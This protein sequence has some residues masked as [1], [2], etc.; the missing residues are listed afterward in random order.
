MYDS[1]FT[2]YRITHPSCPVSM[3]RDAD[4][5]GAVSAACKEN[6]LGFG[7][8]YSKPDWHHGDYWW[9]YFPTPDRHVNYDP[10]RYPERWQRFKDFTHNQIEEIVTRYAPDILW[11]DGGWV[12]P[13]A[14]GTVLDPDLVGVDQGPSQDIDMARIVATARRH[15]PELLVVDRTVHGEYENYR[16]P[17]RRVPDRRLPYPWESC[18][19]LGTDWY[20]SR[21]NDT[22]KSAG[23][24]IRTL[25][26]IV[27]RGGNM[28][29]GIGPDAHGDLI[30]EVYER[31]AEIGDWLEVNG[32]AIYETRPVSGQE[33]D[34]KFLTQSTIRS[35]VYVLLPLDRRYGERLVLPHLDGREIR[36][37]RMLGVASGP[38]WTYESGTPVVDLSGGLLDHAQLHHVACLAVDFDE[39]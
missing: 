13:K 11:L 10:E 16:T 8:Y 22:Y 7:T 9:R 36:A 27:A 19:M 28:L 24:I 31:L 18:I 1:Q 20:S 23:E 5:V 4:V 21:P 15:R 2:D 25:V 33:V 12:R 30:P 3:Y 35:T 26:T 14:A 37:V 32:E 6:G 34:G 17:E 29:L 38:R 39:G